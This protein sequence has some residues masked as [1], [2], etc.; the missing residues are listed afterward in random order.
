[1]QQDIERLGAYVEARRKELGLSQADLAGRG[2]PS[3]TTISKIELGRAT[4]ILP[5][6]ARE[7][8]LALRWAAGSS[9]AI[10]T[11]GEPSL[12]GSASPD[13][14]DE[15]DLRSTSVGKNDD[16]NMEFEIE[17][18]AGDST[19]TITYGTG[20]RL[21]TVRTADLVEVFEAAF[22]RLLNVTYEVGTSA[23]AWKVGPS[24]AADQRT[25]SASSH[26]SILSSPP[27]GDWDAQQRA[28]SHDDVPK[29][30]ES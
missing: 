2:G 1:M 7:L 21:R 13:L 27:R 22:H 29:D 17:G 19:M 10:M 9:E 23:E 11:G 25:T 28:A 6:T 4:R 15:I 12:A 26:T 18:R 5:K 20:S 3:D 14:S 24:P 16:G 30:D 8:D